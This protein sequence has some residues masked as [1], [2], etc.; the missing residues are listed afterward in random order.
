V[1][2]LF[3]AFLGY[4]P[5]QRLLG[6]KVLLS[7]SHQNYLILTGKKFF[8]K[9]ISGAFSSGLHEAFIFALVACLIAAAVS[10]ARGKQA[11]SPPGETQN[12][13]NERNKDSA[14]LSVAGKSGPA[15]SESSEPESEESA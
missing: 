11:A 3:A 12:S 10:S 9:L 15:V 5:I 13:P 1:S 4:N 6:K 14:S 7:L 8:P 2:I